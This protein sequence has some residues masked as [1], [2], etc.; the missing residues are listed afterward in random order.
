MSNDPLA[1]LRELQEENDGAAA[2][3][4]AL[5]PRF[6]RLAER[7]ENG[8]AP[9]AIAVPQLFQTPP[10]LAERLVMLLGL[11]PGDRVLEPSAGLGNLIRPVL[12]AEPSEVVAVDIASD[13]MAELYRLDL[14]RVRLVHG[15]FLTMSPDQLG[16]FDAVAM[17]PPFHLRADIRHILAALA[18][19]RPGGRMAALCLDT[20]QRSDALRGRCFHWEQIPAGAFRSAGTNVPTVL[21]CI[22]K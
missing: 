1:R 13:C 14:P 9:R 4:A 3:Q 19:L 17:N 11:R 12:A 10:H 15:D 6:Q 21:L 16:T 18:F 5:R 7:H 8:T 20:P 22:Q 2:L